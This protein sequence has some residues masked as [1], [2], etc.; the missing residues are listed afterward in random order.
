MWILYL[1]IVCTY[2]YVYDI[3]TMGK[4]TAPM[5]ANFGKIGMVWNNDMSKSH[6]IYVLQ[7]VDV[8]KNT[9][10]IIPHHAKCANTGVV[11][12]PTVCIIKNHLFL[13]VNISVQGLYVWY[14]ITIAEVLV[15]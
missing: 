2:T 6:M 10:V 9:N 14:T 13:E 5:F 7:H 3:C 4:K 12:P 8:C 1:C 15:V 11:S